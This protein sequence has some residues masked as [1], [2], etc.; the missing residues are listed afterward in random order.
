MLKIGLSKKSGLLLILIPVFFAFVNESLAKSNN[1]LFSEIDNGDVQKIKQ[2]LAKGA[3]VHGKDKYGRN[4]LHS[5]VQSGKKEIV[6]LVIDKGANIDAKDK[7]G[8]SPLHIAIHDGNMEIVELLISKGANINVKDNDGIT[9]LYLATDKDF[10]NSDIIKLLILKGAEINV[11][12]KYGLT[13]IV[14]SIKLGNKEVV[15]LMIDKGADVNVKVPRL[16]IDSKKEDEYDY[17][18]LRYAVAYGQLDIVKM[19]ISNG[20]DVKA[21]DKNGNNAFNEIIEKFENNFEKDEAHTQFVNIAKLLISNGVDV[22]ERFGT[23]AGIT[24]LFLAVHI[25]NLEFVSQLIDKGAA[26][27]ARDEYGQT[28]LFLAVE[29]NNVEVAALL[30]ESGADIGIKNLRGISVLEVAKYVDSKRMV[31]LVFTRQE[32]KAWDGVNKK[33]SLQGYK[34]YLSLYPEGQ[35]AA[36]ALSN[37]QKLK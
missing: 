9:P 31:D 10:T 12:N 17:T 23:K 1:D 28:P 25:G 4:L 36:L 19:L 24:P 32:Q 33:A 3:N 15:E 27:N 34:D 5:A 11:R 13:P 30:I 14:N 16:I 37:I 29:Q 35:H 7:D 20:A 21:K 8:Q 18:P 22:N 2:L 26:V 6:E